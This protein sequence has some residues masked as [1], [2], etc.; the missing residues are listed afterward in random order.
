MMVWG[1]ECCGLW[2]EGCGCCAGLREGCCIGC[3]RDYVLKRP[4]S[5]GFATPVL[6]GCWL[7]AKLG[8]CRDREIALRAGEVGVRSF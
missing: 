1:E 4:E 8:E 6:G 7:E 5:E 2:G 3:V